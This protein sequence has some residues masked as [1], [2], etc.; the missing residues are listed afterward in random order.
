MRARTLHVPAGRIHRAVPSDKNHNTAFRQSLSRKLAR[1]TG[2]DVT[3]AS[4]PGQ[5]VSV[6]SA[7]AQVV[8]ATQE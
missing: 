3:V 5:G 1:M 4:E 2:G 6:Y 7:A 8:I